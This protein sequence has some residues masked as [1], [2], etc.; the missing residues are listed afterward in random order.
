M[1]SSLLEERNRWRSEFAE[2]KSIDSPWLEDYRKNRD[3][4]LWRSTRAM[5]KLCEYVLY[6]EEKLHDQD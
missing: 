6:L 3:S 4:E 1:T 5:E 2:G